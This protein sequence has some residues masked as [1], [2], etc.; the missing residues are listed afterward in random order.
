MPYVMTFFMGEELYRFVEG[1][2]AIRVEDFVAVH[3]G[4]EVF[5][6]AEVYDIVG[7]ARKHVNALDI[8]TRDFPFQHLAL[9]V[10]EAALLNKS[11]SCYD[12]EELPL[13]VVPVLTLRDAGFADIDAY[14]SA[15]ERL[16]EFC[17]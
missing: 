5:G 2:G 1:V 10:V 14:L 8:V 6:I 4:D 16:N 13:G 15:V 11:M 17:E 12:N 9:G 3:D 7:V